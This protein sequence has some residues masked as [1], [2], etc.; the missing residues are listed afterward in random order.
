M[1]AT[2]ETTSEPVLKNPDAPAAT[3]IMDHCVVATEH[4][5]FT[6]EMVDRAR[7]R[8]AGQRES[9]SLKTGVPADTASAREPQR[10]G[11]RAAVL[12]R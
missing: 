11:A 2:T 3:R 10:A 5:T 12:S 7:A 4:G 1:N 9:R 8:E 6:W